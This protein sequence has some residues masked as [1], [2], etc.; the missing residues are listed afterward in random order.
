MKNSNILLKISLSNIFPEISNSDIV[1][2]IGAK[3][4][5]NRD[6][7]HVIY[8]TSARFVSVK[9][10]MLTGLKLASLACKSVF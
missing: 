10:F 9:V 5:S 2:R 6:K 8:Q 7:T 1:H 4:V 3:L